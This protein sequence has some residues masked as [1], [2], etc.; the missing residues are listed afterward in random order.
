MSFGMTLLTSPTTPEIRDREDRSLLV[1]VDGD[2][3]LRALHPDHVLGG[4]RD[5]G[6][7]VDRR[8]D[9]LAGLADLMGVG[10]PARVDDR[11]GGS[12]R[13]L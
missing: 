4:P 11:P 5:P 1:L 6:R 12:W 2:D 3:V 7:D 13:A 8:L 10:H 9:G